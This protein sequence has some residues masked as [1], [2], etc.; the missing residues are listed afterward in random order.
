MK[1]GITRIDSKLSVEVLDVFVSCPRLRVCLYLSSANGGAVIAP[2]PK[3]Q[4]ATTMN[5]PRQAKWDDVM[6]ST[7]RI[8]RLLG[9][10]EHGISEPLQIPRNVIVIYFSTH[11]SQHVSLSLSHPQ[12]QALL[13]S[14]PVRNT[15]SLASA[16]SLAI[17]PV[18]CPT[19]PT[20]PPQRSHDPSIP[21][22][23]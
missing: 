21:A 5:P 23:P 17:S 20:D 10:S 16:S 14:T 3:H 15:C 12:I 11:I 2:A 1:L 22:R 9:I 7:S 13:L 19:T 4:Q 18:P 8:R 6:S